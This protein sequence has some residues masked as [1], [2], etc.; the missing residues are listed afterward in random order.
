MKALQAKYK[1]DRA[2][3]AQEQQRLYKERGVSP[4][5][6]CLP[7]V[8]TLFLLGPCTTSSRPGLQAPNITSMLTVFGV[9]VIDV[10]CQPAA[11]TGYASCIDPYIPWLGWLPVIDATGFHMPGYPD[12]LNASVPEIFSHAP[13]HRLRRLP[14]G[15][16]GR[17]P[18]AHPDAHGA[19]QD[20]RSAAA[21]AEPDDAHPARH[22]DHLR[23][24]P[25]GRPLPLLDHDHHLLHH[26]AVPH[27]RLG[28]ALPAA[29]LG[30]RLCPQPQTA[31]SR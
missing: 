15:P 17:L 6:G 29:R 9:Q 23:R 8:L 27:R 2:K 3:L 7:A 4:A 10:T 19:D 16:R 21:R 30:P 5:S 14:A 12:G 26:P 13:D 18:A 31:L 24:V 28:R 25:A 1:G 11:A 20:R 22:L